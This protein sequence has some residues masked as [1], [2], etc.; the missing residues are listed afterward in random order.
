MNK[1]SRKSSST[2]RDLLSRLASAALFAGPSLAQAADTYF[3]LNGAT[4]G[5]GDYSVGGSNNWASGATNWTTSSAGD[6]AT[7][8]WVSGNAAIF[9]YANSSNANGSVRVSALEATPG[10]VA[11]ISLIN[12]TNNRTFTV[13]NGFVSAL[14]LTIVG[15]SA[16]NITSG[17]FR[18]GNLINLQGS[19]TKTGAGD[20]QF[21]GTGGNAYSGTATLS[22][23]RIVLENSVTGGLVGGIGANSNFVVNAGTLG[24]M[25]NTGTYVIGSLSGSGGT[26]S[27]GQDAV[28]NNGSTHTLQVNQATSGTYAGTITQESTSRVL[29]LTKQ[30]ASTLTLSGSHTYTGATTINAGTLLVSSTGSIGAGSAVAVNSGGTLAGTGNVNG[31][32]TVNNGGTLSPG[33]S[34]GLQNL[35]SLALN[36]GGNYNWQILNAAGVA[37]TGYDSHN[38]SG[39]LDLSGLTGAADFNLN[40]WSLASIGPDVNGDALNFINTQDYTWTLIA[41]GFAIT[42]FD[43]TEFTVN[44]GAINGTG[45]FSNALDGSFAV[46]LGDGGT[47][48]VLTYT[49]IPE[50]ATYLLLAGGLMTLL[51]RRRRIRSFEPSR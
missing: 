47:D 38:L 34:P 5:F 19:Y 26:I 1:S 27:T 32:V 2:A 30:G 21:T 20:L 17:A 43:A 42:G 36:N 41:T 37:G 8:A 39:T 51:F 23:G 28:A 25:S 44:L 31:T 10:N 49:A 48:L 15:S 16:V 6:I 14:N 9:D 11:G 45:G 46:N 35:G 13:G 3:D 12:N 18:L 22:A 50:P 29:A 7:S 33:N 40:L 24:L 4:P